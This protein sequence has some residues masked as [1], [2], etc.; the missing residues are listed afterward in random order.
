MSEEQKSITLTL[1]HCDELYNLQC[2][3]AFYIDATTA[4][5]SMPEE[6]NEETVRGMELVGMEIKDQLNNVKTQA[7]KI[8]LR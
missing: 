1:R 2:I 8:H 4:L 5:A 3:T 7:E 6:L